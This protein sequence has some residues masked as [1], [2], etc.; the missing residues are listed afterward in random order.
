MGLCCT[1][2][3]YTYLH[4][5]GDE[6][7]PFYAEE[8]LQF[9]LMLNFSS[10]LMRMKADRMQNVLIN[11][12]V[13]FGVSPSTSVTRAA[14]NAFP[15]GEKKTKKTIRLFKGDVTAWMLHFNL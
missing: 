5:N 7:N 10:F 13:H 4:I 1:V 11:L 8:M 12:L 3:I 9:K 15:A 6:Q 2:N 14:F